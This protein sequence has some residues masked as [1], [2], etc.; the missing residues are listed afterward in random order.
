MSSIRENFVSVKPKCES[1][2]LI[3]ARCGINGKRNFIT[4][5]VF[6]FFAS[7]VGLCRRKDMERNKIK[8]YTTYV[9]I[10]MV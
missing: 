8:F 10:E 2:K 5:T 6:N 4:C 3:N 7:G 1:I 9:N